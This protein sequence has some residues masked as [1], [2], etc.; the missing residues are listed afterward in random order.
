VADAVEVERACTESRWQPELEGS[1]PLRPGIG[2]LV[3]GSSMAKL[4]HDRVVG[5]V[6][7]RVG[8]L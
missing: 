5:V 8:L 4:R 2:R 3:A 7:D 6:L 1:L